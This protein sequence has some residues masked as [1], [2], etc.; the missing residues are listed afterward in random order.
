VV[1]IDSKYTRTIN[2]ELDVKCAKS[3]PPDSVKKLCGSSG[4]GKS[5]EWLTASSEYQ[6]WNR[7][8]SAKLWLHGVSGDGKTVAM[9]Y[10]LRCLSQD[11]LEAKLQDVASVF[12]S[13][14][15]SEMGIV[16]CLASQLLLK[17]KDR[18]KRTRK[19]FP[20][21]KFRQ[22][23]GMRD[24][25]QLLWKLLEASITLVQGFETALIIDGID[26]LDSNTRSSFLANLAKFAVKETTRVLV[27]SKTDKDIQHA[28]NDYSSIDREKERRGELAIPNY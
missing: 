20:I 6:V 2:I 27:S 1:G 16:S 8:G 19:D 3:E 25:T 28:L 7:T 18:A 13:Y 22:C 24:S 26:K 10:V 17:N 11:T 9:S 15:D 5:L 4:I 14:G 23:S 21:S 12:C